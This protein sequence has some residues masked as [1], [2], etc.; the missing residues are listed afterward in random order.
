MA[1]L[2]LGAQTEMPRILSTREQA[3]LIDHWLDLRARQVLPDLLKRAQVDMWILI[4][5]EYNED[6][7]LKTMLPAEWL[8]ARRRTILVIY[9]APQADTV[10]TLA[11]ARYNVG[12][13]FKSAWNPEAQPDQ[14]ARL[15]EII[16]ARQPN[17]IALNY[18]EHFGLA[19]GI[20]RT[21]YD[22]FMQNIPAPYTKRV[23]SGEQLAIAWLE[24][25]LPEEM[26]VY[27]QIM[28]IAHLIIREG[29]S[30]KVI[31]PG[32]TTT[33][34]VQWWYRDRITALG[35]E[36]WFHP[37]VSLQRADAE[38]FDHLRSFSSKP[39]PE[40]IQAG[41]LIHVDFGITYLRLNTDTQ[42]HAYLLKPGEKEVPAGLRKAF[43]IG[44]RLQDILTSQFKTGR[45][46]NEILKGALQQAKTEGIE[47]VIYTH[48]IGYHGHAAGPTIGLWDQQGGVP[49]QGDY[50][51][52]P[53]TAYSI[54][55]NAAVEIPEWNNKKIR[56][57]L[58][59]DGFFDGQTFRYIGQ[60]QT[61]LLLIPRPLANMGE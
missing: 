37:T 31:Q 48:P 6:P 55:L 49:G 44:N 33:Q 16:A 20:N 52:Y 14:W 30:E 42:Q 43:Q 56:I 21:E 53:Q 45:S 15:A 7:V 3:Q 27:P 19:D 29:L 38:R 57:M 40:V 50:P 32:V 5:R 12:R 13:V 2:P 46:G 25:R 9:K 61:E 8:S 18:S 26:A 17:R 60:R 22:L 39:A 54:E 1:A 24:T 35:L 23:V 11:I 59:E 51:L 28:R 58:E 34:E 36:A 47:A 4:S 10:E 41:D